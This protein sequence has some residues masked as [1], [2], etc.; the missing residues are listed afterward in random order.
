M[1]EP[2]RLENFPVSFFSMVMGLAGFTIAWE[3]T[4]AVLGLPYSVSQIMLVITLLTFVVLLGVYALKIVRHREA[5][6]AELSH[7][8]KLSFFPAI[9]I[10]LLLLSIALLKIQPQ[11]AFWF[12]AVGASLHFVMMLFVLNSWINHEHFKIQHMNPAWFIPA[13]GNV[14]VPVAGVDFGYIDVSWF[15]FSIGLLFW[16]VLLTILMNRVL[17]HSPLPEKL[18]PTLFILIAPP[19]VGFLAYLKLAGG[20]DGFAHILYNLALF[21]TLFLLTQIPRLK[22]LPF[23]LSWWAYS[24]PLAAITISTWVMYFHNRASLMKLFALVFLGMLTSVIVL[25]LFRTFL[26]VMNKKVCVPE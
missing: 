20:I 13:V 24:F 6:Y 16:I 7:P 11:L 9:S 14:L 1:S 23:F 22:R 19:A 12:W 8:I 3:K 18:E 4:E 15:F 21:F 26:A 2:Q 10:S 17:F 25:L 5:V